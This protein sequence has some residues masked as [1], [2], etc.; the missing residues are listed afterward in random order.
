MV[1][2]IAL[3]CVLPFILNLTGADFGSSAVALNL[4]VAASLSPQA[5]TD[6]LH[7]ALEGSY[8]HTLLEWSAFCT[9]IFT[10]VLAFAHFNIKH[11]VTTPVIGMALLCAGCMDAFHTL[12]ANRLIEAVAS[13]QNL[14]PFTWALCRL[15][16]AV[17]MIAGVGLCLI[18]T[19][20][21]A[22]RGN[23]LFV[24]AVSSL[25]GLLAYGIIKLCATSESLP[26]TMFPSAFITRPW[27][28][29]PLIL[30]LI[31][32]LW[33]Y[34]IFHRKNPS[35]FSHALIISAVPNIAT[36]LHM[37]FGST[38]LF[39]N[40][41]NIA[42]FLKIIAYV[43]PLLGLIL[44][45]VRTHQTL[46]KRNQ[47]FLLEISERQKAQQELQET[48]QELQVTQ[49]QLVQTE[50]MSSLG[51]L[52]A[53]IA[54]EINNPVSFI[55]GNINPAK[56]YVSDLFELISLYRKHLPEPPDEILEASEIMEVDFIKRDL[57]KLLTS[58]QLG[59]D[60]IRQIVS[61]L[62]AFSRLD[63]AEL[64]EAN[65]HEGID[66]ALVLLGSRLNAAN[67]RSEIEVVKS[68]GSLPLVECYPGQLNQVF[69]NILTNA[70]DA[71][72]E[73]FSKRSPTG[74]GA[75]SDGGCIQ[76]TTTL[77]PNHRVAILIAD[78]GKGIPQ[79]ILNKIFEPFFTTKS[80]GKGTGMGLPISYQ[81]V[82]QN[83]QGNLTC[84]S[85]PGVG[86]TFSIQIPV[87][88]SRS[89]RIEAGAESVG[90]G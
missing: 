18:G 8:T 51:Q 82:T 40:H 26:Q 36:Q 6:A 13:N 17:L 66:S 45:Y 90:K 20:H 41:F 2:A 3:I 59:A 22:W 77:L 58:I 1:G 16:N 68:Y 71:I 49:M 89:Q 65:L 33:I 54:H 63:E 43:V 67:N 38:A 79:P 84:E 27:D 35:I 73:K 61:S 37:A 62:R 69:M 5:F 86:S 11:D 56:G 81:V 70:I 39:D 87:R 53:G 32:G 29:F 23:T 83:H 31:A 42:H 34:P 46:E 10:V 44:D 28:I 74:S 21:K 7:H 72:D 57:P 48:I 4:D 12:A 88:I 55:Y 25:F 78:N 60:R 52:V 14:I 85:T 9:A 64:K 80:V 47:E 50:K 19:R 15:F 30:F 75:V 76:I 24:T